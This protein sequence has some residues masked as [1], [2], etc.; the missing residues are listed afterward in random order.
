[1]Q[2]YWGCNK[3]TY[4]LEPSQSILII[5]IDTPS[6]R[7]LA[8]M[9]KPIEEVSIIHLLAESIQKSCQNAGGDIAKFFKEIPPEELLFLGTLLSND[10]LQYYFFSNLKDEVASMLCTRHDLLR[11]IL[12]SKNQPKWSRRK[13]NEVPYFFPCLL[14][15]HSKM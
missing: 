15:G 13:P 8:L 9:K 4:D 12:S 6:A 1:M 3:H 10:A 14:E 7:I 5:L 2:L 11:K